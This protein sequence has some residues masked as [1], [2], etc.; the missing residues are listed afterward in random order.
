MTNNMLSRK[1]F[2]ILFFLFNLL[3]LPAFFFISQKII[4][5]HDS[6]IQKKIPVYGVLRPFDLIEKNGRDFTL[7]NLRGRIW[8]A[9]FMFTGCPNECPAMNFKM[10]LLQGKLPYNAGL[11][12]FSVDP[13][14]DTPAVL[15]EYARRFKAADGFWR[16]LTGPKA[17]VGRLLEDCHFAKADDPLLHAL[18]LILLDGE[19]RIR[20]Y[21]DYSDSETVKKLTQAIKL[22]KEK[23]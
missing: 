4:R 13:E 15:Q 17:T 8:V 2:R 21:Y 19:G 9:N 16:F 6:K 23:G 5:I 22:L 10:S 11:I 3:A 18:R 20:G 14:K 1:N 7:S 12:S